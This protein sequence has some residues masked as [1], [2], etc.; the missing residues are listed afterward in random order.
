MMTELLAPV[1][2]GVLDHETEA[3]FDD[4][5]DNDHP[6]SLLY[7]PVFDNTNNTDPVGTVS[8]EI[9]WKSLF[10]GMLRN[11]EAVIQAVLE[12]TC[13]DV[14]TFEISIDHVRNLGYGDLHDVSSN[15][16][17]RMSSA[18]VVMEQ[19]SRMISGDT[20]QLPSEY[21]KVF[22]GILGTKALDYDEFPEGF[23]AYR[24]RVYPTYQYQQSSSSGGPLV[25]AIVIAACFV[26]AGI[27]FVLYDRVV[28]S[29]QYKVMETAVQSRAIV[30]SLF[31][32][33][34][35]DRIFGMDQK[36][37]KRRSNESDK[38][39]DP[40]RFLEKLSP[41]MR[42]TAWLKRRD[43]KEES[44]EVNE[45]IA[46]VFQ[47]TTVIFADIAGFTA[48]SSERDPDQV[49][50]LLE[51]LYAGFDKIAKRLGV[52]K[53]ETIGDCYVAV[54]GLPDPNKKHA[55]TMA[56]FASEC[57]DFTNSKVQDLEVQLGPGTSDLQIRIGLHS[58]PVTAGV[59]RG[60]KSRFQLFGDT[61]N[62]AARM[63]SLG[64]PSAIQGQSDN[65]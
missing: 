5:Y 20:M 3:I 54:T 50:T 1:F 47:D 29:R 14:M 56:R 36:P 16:F 53:V 40:T 41:K 25:Y 12:N 10:E 17:E 6:R 9:D 63:E 59:L 19:V 57:I 28:E 23:C 13:G 8:V 22:S 48:W 46:E 27:V 35:R 26:F 65:C 45:S 55:T 62:T 58:G 4:F 43:A 21:T 51:S 24:I 30:D 44:H 37:N 49:F 38:S 61:I 64:L 18:K 32:S 2:S 33:I 31:P 39:I 34:V 7:V 60:E 15:Q 52:F 42:V 11:R